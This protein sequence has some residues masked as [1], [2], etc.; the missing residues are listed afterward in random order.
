LLFATADPRGDR[1]ALAL[2]KQH[3]DVDRIAARK[4]VANLDVTEFATGSRRAREDRI[5]M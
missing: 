4:F 2:Q 1:G 5:V 3:G